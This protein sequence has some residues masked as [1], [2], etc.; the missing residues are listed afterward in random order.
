MKTLMTIVC[1]MKTL[2]SIDCIGDSNDFNVFI[3]DS[4]DFNEDYCYYN[5][6]SHSSNEDPMT[7]MT[8]IAILNLKKVFLSSNEDYFDS[9]KLFMTLIK[10]LVI[11]KKTPMS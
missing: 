7:I 1:L 8:L 3:K 4:Y 6:Y 9:I 10:Y 2:M 11:L 5:E